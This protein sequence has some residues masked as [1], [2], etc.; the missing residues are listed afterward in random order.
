MAI[1]SVVV[2]PEHPHAGEVCS[3]EESSASGLSFDC[4]RLTPG[5][6]FAKGER[7]K[8]SQF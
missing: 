3:S 5:F 6:G 7:I 2:D 4:P 1:S 8:K